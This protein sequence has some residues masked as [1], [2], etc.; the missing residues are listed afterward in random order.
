MKKSIAILFACALFGTVRSDA[1]TVY[2]FTIDTSSL[3]AT[4]ANL[5]FQ[6]NPGGVESG[7]VTGVISN[8]ITG[9]SFDPASI[10]L[11][12]DATGTLASTLTLDNGA[13]YNDAFQPITLGNQV[14]FLLTLS[15]PGIDMPTSVG[16][17]FGFS[18]YDFAGTTP[19]L[20]TA[21][22]G[23]IA[24]IEADEFAGVA[25]YTNNGI[26][27]VGAPAPEPSAFVLAGLGGCALLLRRRKKVV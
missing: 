8:F 22:D 18:I 17:F 4:P 14:Q 26:A 3:N 13:V 19:L 7:A 27:T 5:D 20:T 11:T 10:V 15:G 23:T 16:T 24:G 25:P 2:Q 9:G 12:G 21:L 1:A 6:L